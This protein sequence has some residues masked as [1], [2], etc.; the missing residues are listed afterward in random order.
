MTGTTPQGTTRAQLERRA[1][2]SI[3]AGTQWLGAEQ[4]RAWG[5]NA[6]ALRGG[7][8][9]QF[10]TNEQLFW[11]Q[12]DGQDAFPRYV[13][14]DDLTALPVMRDIMATFRGWH[15][16][17]IAAWFESTSSYLQGRRPR[18]LVAIAPLLVLRAA[19]DA[20]IAA[21]SQDS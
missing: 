9:G 3:R 6:I 17:R 15:S 18:E 14:G 20:V 13:L 19:K 21:G 11:I 16:L 8:D 2:E 10:N 1:V 4:L 5:A 7:Q 12:I